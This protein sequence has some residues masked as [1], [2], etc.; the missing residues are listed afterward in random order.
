MS[1]KWSA[2]KIHNIALWSTEKKAPDTYKFLVSLTN[3]T[4]KKK[5]KYFFRYIRKI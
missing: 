4:N 1:E 3:Q 5:L 2:L